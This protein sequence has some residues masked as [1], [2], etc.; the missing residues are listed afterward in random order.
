MA[1]K[2]SNKTEVDFNSLSHIFREEMSALVVDFYE[3]TEVKTENITKIIKNNSD[4]QFNK[5]SS[6]DYINFKDENT[7]HLQFRYAMF[8]YMYSIFE[9][10]INELFKLS[11]KKNSKIRERY[12]TKFIELDKLRVE[13]KQNSI[14]NTEYETATA[15][16]KINIQ[17]KFIKE[18]TYLLPPLHN[19][20]YFYDISDEVMWA[21]E[22]LKFDFTEMRA[23]RNLLTHR[24][25][26]YDE[27]YVENI[28]MSVKKSK[29]ISDPTKR[30]EQYH[31]RKFFAFGNI[32]RKN[33][34]DLINKNTPI[35]I[36][37]SDSYFT[38]CF[39]LLINIYFVL[40]N[41]ATKSNNLSINFSHEL[42]ELGKKLKNSN[43]Y[44]VAKSMTY[45]FLVNYSDKNQDND[46]VK[47]NYLLATREINKFKILYNKEIVQTKNEKEFIEYFANKNEPIYNLLL[48]L[49]NDDFDG[50]LNNLKKVKNLTADSRNWFIFSDLLTYKDF[51]AIFISILVKEN[52]NH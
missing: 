30:V 34:F 47:A 42:M 46:F 35:N 6:D 37:I 25:T 1:T 17:L 50:C 29:K 51:E 40:W 14:R 8:N 28:Q 27:E 15:T 12:V 39:F 45:N 9:K 33:L 38:H 36:R 21:N 5:L 26:K 23:R 18:I 31:E 22:D 16:K 41:N 43:F 11:I 19:W 13:N 24:G 49:L 3:I 52:V 48:C 32:K 2:V 7:K 44:F 10:H 4:P 20:Q